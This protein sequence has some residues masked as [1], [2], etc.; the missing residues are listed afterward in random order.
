MR[1][2]GQVQSSFWRSS[3]VRGTADEAGWSDGAKLLA[4][5]LLTGPHTAALGCFPLPDG[6]VMADLGWASETVV[7]RFAE[8]S[9]KGYAYRFGDVVFLPNFLRW[10]PI[11]NG[12]IA[13]ARLIELEALPSKEAKS[14][15][16]RALLA[17]CAFLNADQKVLL[18]T[19]SKGLPKRYAKSDP[20]LTDPNQPKKPARKRATSVDF[21]TWIE[22][23]S[24]ADAIPADD[25]I[26]EYARKAGI[27]IDFLELSW[28]R[29]EEAMTDGGKSQKDWRAHYRNAV[30]GNWYKLWW[31][32]PDGDCKL[33]TQG[34]QARRAA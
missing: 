28:K 17:F 16:A 8:L 18:E 25:P 2:Y 22:S 1:D 33:T 12:N 30:K 26:F 3:D 23:L 34:E 20:I 5:Y 15:A 31:F 27:P 29:F 13:K 10:N 21:R 6:Y 9:R 24:G 14:H 4:L 19:L 7:E 32:T 11:Q